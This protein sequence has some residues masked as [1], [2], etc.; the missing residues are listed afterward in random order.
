MLGQ[1][2][3]LPEEVT[4]PGTVDPNAVAA[5]AEKLRR[6]RIMLI[7]GVALLGVVVVGSLALTG[8]TAEKRS[9]RERHGLR[10]GERRCIG[11]VRYKIMKYGPPRKI[12]VC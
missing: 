9:Y 5:A 1:D 4:T 11:N 3:P 7:G 2:E 12:G 10:P 6:Q 8:L